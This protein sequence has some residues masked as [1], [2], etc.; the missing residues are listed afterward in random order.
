MSFSLC[1]SNDFSGFGP[2]LAFD[3]NSKKSIGLIRKA[4]KKFFIINIEIS[5]YHVGRGIIFG[6]ITN[7]RT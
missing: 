2:A 7:V 3:G 4:V 6:F 1:D 5:I